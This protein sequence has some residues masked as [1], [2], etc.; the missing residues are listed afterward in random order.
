MTIEMTL[1]WGYGRYHISDYTR[2]AIAIASLLNPV[3]SRPPRPCQRPGDVNDIVARRSGPPHMRSLRS[4]AIKAAFW[5]PRFESKPEPHTLPAQ[6]A[7]LYNLITYG[8]RSGTA[9][10]Q[11]RLRR[12]GLRETVPILFPAVAAIEDHGPFTWIRQR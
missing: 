3:E 2:R 4:T 10:P 8:R 5:L 6:L 12:Q 9:A 11:S 7:S 1:G